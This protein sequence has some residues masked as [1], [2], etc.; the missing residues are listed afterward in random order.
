[1]NEFT[2]ELLKTS[3]KDNLRMLQI[4]KYTIY[5]ALNEIHPLVL[6]KCGGVDF[7]VSDVEDI[8]NDKDWEKDLF[9]E[10]QESIRHEEES[11][12]KE[13]K[14]EEYYRESNCCSDY[15][16]ELEITK[17]QDLRKKVNKLRKLRLD[18][19]DKLR[20]LRNGE[21]SEIMNNQYNFLKNQYL[22]YEYEYYIDREPISSDD[23]KRVTNIKLIKIF[24]IT[25]KEQT[26]MKSIISK[27][28]IKRR[29]NLKRRE[30]RRND[31]GRTKRREDKYQMECKI[32]ELISQNP[33]IKKNEVAAKVGLDRSSMSR[34]YRHL[35]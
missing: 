30:D 28:E 19:L 22:T 27:E 29:K 33:D 4:E 8:L 17:K 14:I 20:D 2:V 6:S 13:D 15:E 12:M 23:F 10:E 24:K 32:K 21:L 7:K 1:M 16:L 25:M 26:Q 5:K 34:T 9:D 35:F 3:I 31:F 18:D 11:R